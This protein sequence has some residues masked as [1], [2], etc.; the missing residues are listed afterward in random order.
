[1]LLLSPRNTLVGAMS[2]LDSLGCGTVLVRSP[3][4]PLVQAMLA[5]G[6]LRSF[7]VPDLEGLLDTEYARYPYD[8]DYNDTQQEPFV[9]L[10]TSGSTGT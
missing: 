6:H 10:H 2:L 5:T 7:D 3:P 4:N 1:M 9:A 8:K